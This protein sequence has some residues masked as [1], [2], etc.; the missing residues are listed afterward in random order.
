ME[1]S[2]LHTPIEYLKGVGPQR[3]EIL[4]KEL[5]IHF[6]K[7]FIHLF[8]HRY[9]DKTRYYKINELQST[10][11]DV[12]I[13]GKITHLKSIESAKNFKGN[14]LTALFE[15]ETGEMELVWFQ[16]QKW[17][18]ENIKLNTPYVLF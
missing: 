2:I 11:A 6:F 3:G 17:I 10:N 1:N 7:D 15:D 12:Q 8:P 4:R 14:R 9:I 13:I 5:N 18:K 16:G